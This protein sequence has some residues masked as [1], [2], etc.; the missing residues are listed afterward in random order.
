MGIFP[1]TSMSLNK[2]PSR[3]IIPKQPHFYKV[4]NTEERKHVAK[5]KFV[6]L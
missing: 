1:I 6:S 3:L 2:P 4:E 5:E